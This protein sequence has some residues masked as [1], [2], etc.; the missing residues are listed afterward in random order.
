MQEKI[1]KRWVETILA[2]YPIKPVLEVR[3]YVEE[4][5]EKIVAAFFDMY[6]GKEVEIDEPINDLMRFLA[7][8]RNLSP[9]DS[10]KLL[11]NLK[12]IVAEEMKLSA[13]DRVRLYEVMDEIAFKAFDHYMACREK[14]FELRLREKD[15]DLEI[16]RKIIEF[17]Q[18][19][20]D[21]KF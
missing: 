3:Q 12:H 8:D 11:V 13:Q 7:T 9:G 19:A 15:R 18:K 4:A 2:N 10:L 6:S 1:V 5:A 20:D 16:M 21:I 17:A 14:I